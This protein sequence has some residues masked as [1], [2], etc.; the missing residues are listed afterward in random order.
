MHFERRSLAR[1]RGTGRARDRRRRRPGHVRAQ[2]QVDDRLF[3]ALGRRDAD[4]DPVAQDGRPVAEHGDLGHAVRNEDHA[5]APLSK[6]PHDLEHALREVRRQR[7][8]DLVQHQNMRVGSERAREIDQP[9]MG[10]VDVARH[11][12]E[13]EP[14]DPK[15]V[16]R[17]LDLV[18]GHAGETHVLRH[19]EIRNNGGILID[20]HDA[21]AARFGRRSKGH[22]L[23][24]EDHF[25]LVRR[26]HAGDDLDQR[27]L[28]RSV[29]AHERVRFAASHLE[30]RRAQ[31]SDRAERLRDAANVEKRRSV[32]HDYVSGKGRRL[33]PPASLAAIQLKITGLCKRSAARAC[34]AYREAPSRR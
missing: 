4:G 33:A 32:V 8:G 19:R 15:L 14:L 9:Q 29:R 26:E 31:G 24:R 21:G 30:V 13:I 20:G 12:P 6:I 7:G 3:G 10:E 27:A 25:A 22:R 1:R 34:N 18:E 17:R 2:H 11:R 28:A 23:T 16:H 5:R